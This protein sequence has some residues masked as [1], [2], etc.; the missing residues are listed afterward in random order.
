MMGE[1]RRYFRDFSW[2]MRGTASL[3]ELHVQIGRLPQ[4]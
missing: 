3:R 4:I 2:G 1:V